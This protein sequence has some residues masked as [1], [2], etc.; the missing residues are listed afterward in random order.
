MAVDTTIALITLAEAKS[1]L[2]I[3]T[4]SEDSIVGDLINECSVW[5]NTYCGRKLIY[6][7]VP[8]TEYYDGNGTSQLFL[9]NWPI[10]TVTSLYMDY[11]RAWTADTAID[12]TADVQTDLESGILTLWNNQSLYGQGVGNVRVIYTAGYTHNSNVPYDLKLACKKLAAWKYFQDYSQRRYG[13]ASESTGERQVNYSDEPLL[14]DVKQILN[15][16]RRLGA[17]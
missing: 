17:Q 7:A 16:Y 6:P 2:K 15:R 4:T 5:I 12:L 3:T 11:L 13:V 8:Y 14:P 1:F 9:K 10:I